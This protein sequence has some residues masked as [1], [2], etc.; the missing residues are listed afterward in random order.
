MINKP[1]YRLNCGQY[2]FFRGDEPVTAVMDEVAMA[3]SRSDCILHKH[4]SV[5]T[6]TLWADL[7]RSKLR[8]SGSSVAVEMA[9]DIIVI[10]GRFPVAELNRCLLN[11]GYVGSF[12]KR[13]EAG[14]LAPEPLL[15]GPAS[16]NMQAV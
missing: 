14:E 9:E 7:A 11:S 3:V 15:T 12:L 10:S 8:A 13:I 4:G 2:V 16:K 5:E 1:N 6:V